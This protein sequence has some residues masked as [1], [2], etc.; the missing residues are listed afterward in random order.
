MI[1]DIYI[2]L[3]AQLCIYIYDD[4][5]LVVRVHVCAVIDEDL[6]G[7]ELCVPKQKYTYMYAIWKSIDEFKL[8]IYI[9]SS[10]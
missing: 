8:Y 6:N 7:G 9:Y 10:G 2:L 3:N 5:H 1:I 4:S